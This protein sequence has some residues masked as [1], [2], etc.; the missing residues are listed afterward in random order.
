MTPQPTPPAQ[1]GWFS[2]NWKW[3]VGL[4]CLG[5]L[6]CCGGS[7]VVAAVLGQDLPAAS[8][9]CGKPGPGG[10]DCDV[11]RTS[12]TGAFKACWDLEITC[13]NRGT[14]LG[15]ACATVGAAEKTLVANMPA[16]GFSNQDACDVPTA[17]T[18]KD[19]VVT[20]E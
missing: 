7:A 18:V 10:V 9:N 20:A 13:A 11:A 15:H 19:L 5:S 14:M 2:Q 3:L 12:G 17:G 1:A 8:V 16:D 6:L 4:G